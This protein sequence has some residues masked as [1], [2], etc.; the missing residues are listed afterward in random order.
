MQGAWLLVESFPMHCDCLAFFNG[1][2][3]AYGDA[4]VE[5]IA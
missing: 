4:S 3:A 1:L 5:T 2:H